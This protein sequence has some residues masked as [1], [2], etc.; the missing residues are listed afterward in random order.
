MT[1]KKGNLIKKGKATTT[2]TSSNAKTL[3]SA[4]A[5]MEQ[6]QDMLQPTASNTPSRQNPHKKQQKRLHSQRADTDTEWEEEE[7]LQ[8]PSPSQ[9]KRPKKQ[10]N[11]LP[12]IPTPSGG[13]S[14]GC[15]GG[16]GDD[17]GTRGN[18]N[19]GKS[20]YTSQ[21]VILE[22]IREDIKAHPAKLSK[23]FS[24]AKP[25]VEL[26]QGGLRMTASR[27]VLVIPK[28]PKD[29]CS[30][31]KPDAFPQNSP[32]GDSVKARVPKSQQ[33]THQV[34][35]RN[36]DTSVTE[37]EMEEMLRTQDFPFKAIK[38]IHSRANNVPTTIFRLILKSEDLK[39]RLLKDGI[40][41]DQMH[42]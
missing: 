23:A 21:A 20:E 17:G 6:L 8:S 35:I 40:F 22:G 26:K 33:I 9:A 25:N 3:Q 14:I 15:S 12:Q 29:C 28:N 41:L 18:N 4:A 27:D 38:R 34:V 11:S 19:N 16:G 1:N 13:G 32:L 2:N 39:R 42:F 31:L 7:G 24:S 37:E 30:L 36:V 10:K 5:L